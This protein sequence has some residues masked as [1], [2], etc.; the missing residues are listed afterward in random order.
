[1]GEI[2]ESVKTNKYLD[3][4]GLQKFWAQAK[5]YI[6]RQ[7]RVISDKIEDLSNL[8]ID[9]LLVM[10]KG[11]ANNSAVLNG[12]YTISG[13]KYK[14]RA[15]SQISMAL[16]AAT[17][18]GLKGWY[19]SKID[20]GS[21][22]VI[23][24]SD[25]Q[26]YVL[27]N[28][29]R[30]GSWSSGTPNIKAG[31]KISIVN[32][33]KYD[34]CGEVKSVSGNKI[35]LKEALPFDSLATSLISA[36]DPDDWTI[37]LP[38]RADAGIIDMGGGALAEGVNTQATNIGAHAEGIQTHAYGQYSHTE[39]FQTKAGYAAH[40]EGGNTV[41]EG[42]RSHAEGLETTASGKNAHAEGNKT[43]AS[44]ENA[45]AEGMESEASGKTSH[46]EGYQTKATKDSSHAEG[47]KT[48]AT[49]VR[50]H[51]EGSE[52]VASGKASHAEGS[53]TYAEG[54]Y[55]HTEGLGTK[56]TNEAEH[57][58]GKYN[59]SVT[60]TTLFSVGNGTSDTDR[61][62]A[63]EITSDGNAYIGETIKDNKIATLKDIPTVDTELNPDSNNP[64]ANS[65][66]AN[67]VK[68]GVHFRG[69]YNL[70]PDILEGE[71][72]EGRMYSYTDEFGVV[73]VGD[74]V[75]VAGDTE[76][77]TEPT[78]E[79]IVC[80]IGDG[81]Y[82]WI[83]LGDVTPAQNMINESLKNYYKKSETYKRSEVDSKISSV[84]SR[85]DE[86][87]PRHT[88]TNSSEGDDL[89][90]VII[91]N[92]DVY[93]GGYTSD[94]CRSGDVM[95]E[96]HKI[97][98]MAYEE[99][100]DDENETDHTRS[101]TLELSVERGLRLNGD[102]VLTV[103]NEGVLNKDKF[104]VN[105]VRNDIDNDRR[106]K[107]SYGNSDEGFI[108]AETS[109][110]NDTFGSQSV[111]M[112]GVMEGV[113]TAGK[114]TYIERSEEED[115]SYDVTSTSY[116]VDDRSFYVVSHHSSGDDDTYNYTSFNVDA[117]QGFWLGRYNSEGRGSEVGTVSDG[118]K[119][120]AENSPF[121]EEQTSSEMNVLERAIIMETIL[122]DKDGNSQKG[123]TIMTVND[124][125][126]LHVTD[127]NAETAL[128]VSST[129]A[130]I[131]NVPILTGTRIED[132]KILGLF[133]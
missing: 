42:L 69:V 101:N 108:I 99:Y 112:M 116:E 117:T 5:T 59:K 68:G 12:E 77:P 50:S 106:V 43:A 91:K 110:P 35:T 103:D 74:I 131:N 32:D 92:Q 44:G 66:V 64:I 19:Y 88:S 9:D 80:E 79:Y 71:D 34:Y 100:A 57:A 109:T 130:S 81:S 105:G 119:I 118:V 1:M 24:L 7:D 39:G 33:S 128:S 40:A 87:V 129:G 62:N 96:P 132:S 93:G 72:S 70:L 63:F 86:Y 25:E 75:I 124:A 65:V 85:F 45:H 28:A 127:I 56:T 54:H 49:G 6:D 73:N 114:S 90:L 82:S 123:S 26:P 8:D 84:D 46:S 115:S 67:A 22:P 97:T 37:Y 60:G 10:G 61:K 104:M 29:L 120:K 23:T 55:S 133:S 21:N 122:K 58:S 53:E 95:V 51:A 14:N 11:D 31:D 83:E 15:I 20:F 13:T 126:Y 102:E 94:L 41:A 47:W 78:K 3:L 52:T 16:G 4:D 2:L 36:N 18:A 121:N 89:R 98:L 76:F 113:V 17:T 111:A 48:Q 38:E 27:V 30:G 107:Y 125:I